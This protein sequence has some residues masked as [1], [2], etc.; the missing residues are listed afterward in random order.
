M[1]D[2]SEEHYQSDLKLG[3]QQ[4]AKIPPEEGDDGALLPQKPLN[5]GKR[6]TLIPEALPLF[7]LPIQASMH[8]P[9]LK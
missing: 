6:P 4:S 7:A 1:S 5:L 9:E 2:E 3:T 8:E